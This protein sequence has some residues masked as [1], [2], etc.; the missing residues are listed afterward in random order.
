LANL[1]HRT[2]ERLFSTGNLQVLFKCFITRLKSKYAFPEQFEI[3]FAE[4]R[5]ENNPQVTDEN[6]SPRIEKW[7]AIFLFPEYKLGFQLKTSLETTQ[8]LSKSEEKDFIEILYSE[9]IKYGRFQ[10]HF[11][12][13]V[14]DFEFNNRILIL[15]YPGQNYKKVVQSLLLKFPYLCELRES[16]E[17]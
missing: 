1:D 13:I 12:F 17:V 8:P 4:T 6:T 2:K 16:A 10:Q 3:E 15:S 14:L 7:P 5:F 9:M 11:I